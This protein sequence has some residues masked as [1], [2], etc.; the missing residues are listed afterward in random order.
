MIKLIAA[1]S[2]N[3]VIG[4]KNNELPWKNKYPEDMKFF[5]EK[6]TG[7]AIIMGKNT[8]SSMGNKPLPKR[9]NIVLSRKL[10]P[11]LP[12]TV[13]SY[14]NLDDAIK[15]CNGECWIIGGSFV[16]QDSLRVA[17]ELYL[18]TI[19]EIITEN[20]P[21]YFPYV[22][23]DLFELKEKINLSEKLICNVF[24]RIK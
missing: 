10:T 17:E 9:R 5:R 23:P 4:N 8:F 12:E 20:D 11:K 18:T 2:L 7:S 14:L 1:I 13:E 6:T 21:I 24:R 15:A 3:S 16:Y 19:P 22:N